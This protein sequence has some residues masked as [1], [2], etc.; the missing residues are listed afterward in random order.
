MARTLTVPFERTAPPESLE[1]RPRKL[2]AWL[3]TLPLAN[4]LECARR[5]CDHLHAVNR[6]KLDLDVRLDLLD[7]HCAFTEG[8]F[9]DLD[10]VCARSGLPLS[11]RARCAL[12]L[13]QEL[14][15]EIALGY[16]VAAAESRGKI[17]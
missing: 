7:A 3:D 17:L 15:N 11:A 1:I 12:A 4:S 5:A 9:E 2:R 8:I 6:A 10:A 16:R 14:A 13:G